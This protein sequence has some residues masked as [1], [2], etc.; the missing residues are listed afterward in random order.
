[1]K[2]VLGSGSAGRKFLMEE[3][4]Y[5]FSV[6]T[7][8]IDEK[9]IRHDDPYQLV[10]DIGRAKAEK[11][12]PLIKEP[13]I[14]ITADTIVLFNGQIREKPV[15]F[16]QAMDFMRSY[17]NNKAEVVTGVVLLNTATG[18]REEKVVSGAVAFGDMP[19]GVMEAHV[20]SYGID[21]AGAMKLE[22]QKLAPYITAVNSSMDV[23]IGLPGNV[24]KKFIK[25]NL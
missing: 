10:L 1:M 19:E 22:D 18:R 5:D 20:K 15:S 7:A 2:I 9:T 24:I 4:G 12:L 17:C 13:S 25:E 23:L 14:L 8:D 21:G 11:I 16:E 3:W 6:L